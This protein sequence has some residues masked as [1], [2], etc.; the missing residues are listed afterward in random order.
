MEG[1]DYPTYEELIIY[2]H[3]CVNWWKKIKQAG[4][5]KSGISLLAH[6]HQ[7]YVLYRRTGF[8]GINCHILNSN[9]QVQLR[10]LP[11]VEPF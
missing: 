3:F 6:V 10:D 7:R 8:V 9:Q 11:S 4:S 5:L 2:L 1:K